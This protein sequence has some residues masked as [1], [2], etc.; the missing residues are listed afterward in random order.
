MCYRFFKQPWP[1]KALSSEVGVNN[2]HF[3]KSGSS[4]AGK[5]LI[6]VPTIRADLDECSACAR[7][8]RTPVPKLVKTGKTGTYTSLNSLSGL[9]V[10]YKCPICGYDTE[11]VTR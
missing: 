6:P 10:F 7:A 11:R 9:V 1:N 5:D 4:L 2:T 8:G 3:P